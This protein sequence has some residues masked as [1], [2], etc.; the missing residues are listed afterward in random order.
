M[1]VDRTDFLARWKEKN[2]ISTPQRAKAD[3]IGPETILHKIVH[4]A[5]AQLYLGNVVVPGK[6]EP[7]RAAGT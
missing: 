1:Q 3:R 6:F 5:I 7:H 4:P 2:R